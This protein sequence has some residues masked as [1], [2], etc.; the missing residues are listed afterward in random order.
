MTGVGDIASFAIGRKGDAIWMG[1][2]IRKH[3]YQACR[4][5]EHVNRRWKAVGRSET[6]FSPI[7]RVREENQVTAGMFK[8]DHIVERVESSTGVVVEQDPGST[9][10]HGVYPYEA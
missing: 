10:I 9:D 4:R 5:V 8:N 7:W 2:V 3:T 6:L 1:K